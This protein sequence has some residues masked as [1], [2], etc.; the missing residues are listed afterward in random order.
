[1]IS[2][3]TRTA[4]TVLG[5]VI[6]IGSVIIVYSA[7][8]GIE[9]LVVGQ[10][11]SFGTDIIQTEIK[12]PTNK[13]ISNTS[14]AG[15]TDLVQGTQITSMTLDDMEDIREI[16]NIK[17]TYPG[18]MGQ[19]QLSYGNEQR[20]A[21]VLGTNS[22]YINVDQSTIE[23]GRFFDEEEN[24]SQSLVIV[25]GSK[26]KEKLFGDNEALGKLVKLRKTKFRVVGIMK[27]RGAVMGMDF[28]DFVY[29]P[30][31]TLQK[32]IMGINHVSYIVSQLENNDLADETALEIRRVMRENHDIKVEDE[33]EFNKDDFRVVTMSE[34]MSLLETVTGALTLLLLA[35]VA[36]SLVVGGV[37]IMNIMY[38]IVSERSAEIGLRKA[39]G[40]T[41][42][43]IMW[44]FLIESIIITVAGGIVGII[45]GIS[46]SYFISIGA[47]SSGLDWEFKVPVEAYFVSLGFSTFFGI[48]FGVYPAKKAAKLDPIVALR[49]E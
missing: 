18:I 47:N 2:N 10:V 1:M 39:V 22:S 21:F 33:E 38:V 41:Y 28:D 48:V 32:R 43:D 42:N 29:V 35:I 8:Y 14:A 37:G 27:E 12:V 34:M 45:F 17:D 15:S 26:M 49:N 11:E 30:V 3:K 24:R 6:G 7:G 36:I 4:L 9:R 16:P 13:S 40:A 25:L 23:F 19:E 20:K 5:M 44:Q 31:K 46:I